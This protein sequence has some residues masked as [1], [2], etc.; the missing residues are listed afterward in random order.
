MDERAA[1][2]HG[3]RAGR[4]GA[5][6][7]LFSWTGVSL[8]ATGASALRARLSRRDAGGALSLALADAAGEPLASVDALILRPVSDA[9]REWSA[10]ERGEEAA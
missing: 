3:E 9:P 7:L 6:S 2:V 1:Q 5:A 10:E 4:E 8:R